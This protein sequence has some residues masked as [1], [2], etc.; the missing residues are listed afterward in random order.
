MEQSQRTRVQ[1]GCLLVSICK[2]HSRAD[3]VVGCDSLVCAF[4]AGPSGRV[5][6]IH[7]AHFSPL[8]AQNLVE[9][10]SPVRAPS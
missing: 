5:V 7:F 8:R 9:L 1:P 3:L 4:E 10:L 6:R 2:T